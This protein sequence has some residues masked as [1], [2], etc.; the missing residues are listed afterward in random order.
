[1]KNIVS[2]LSSFA[3]ALDTLTANINFSSSSLF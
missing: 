2:F 1:M 3:Y